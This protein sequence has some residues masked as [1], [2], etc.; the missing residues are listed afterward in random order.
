MAR[1]LPLLSGYAADGVLAWRGGETICASRFTAA[2]VALADRLPRRRHV[3]NLCEERYAFMLGYAASL[4]A[5]QTTLLPPSRA[6]QALREACRDFADVYCLSDRGAIATELHTVEMRVEVLDAPGNAQTEPGKLEVDAEQ[7]A[8]IVFTSGST[9][10]HMPHPKSLESLVAGA[11]TL[12]TQL[13]LSPGT[14]ILSTLPPQHMF[15]LESTVMLPMQ[16]GLAVHAGRP[17]LPADLRAAAAALPRPLWLM[18]SPLHLRACVAE[19]VALHDVS[20]VLC[21]TMPLAG[22]LAR[23]VERLW[24]A[25]LYEIYGSSEAGMIAMRRTAQDET[26]RLVPGLR[27]TERSGT[28][29]VQGN[30]VR[31]PQPVLD[32]I[33]QLDAERFT[34]QGRKTDVVKIAGKRTSLEALE[35]ALLAVEG[36]KDGVFFVPDEPAGGRLLAFAVAP[37]VSAGEIRAALRQRIDAVF[38]PRPLHLVAELPRGDSGKIPRRALAE[39]AAALGRDVAVED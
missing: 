24:K 15:G 1:T 9:G 38:L 27:F 12:G 31:E 35:A 3:L 32:R 21:S 26:W 28:L 20:G 30:H 10:R 37:G 11:R 14:M 23:A 29:W 39:L 6:P 36:V 8:A 34:L 33:T 2:A 7:I 4:L 22:E 18:T 16:N 19:S 25:P 5:G 17:L 13:A